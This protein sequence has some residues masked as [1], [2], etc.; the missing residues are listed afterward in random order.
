MKTEDRRTLYAQDTDRVTIDLVEIFGAFINP[1]IRLCRNAQAI[2]SHGEI[3]S[4]VGMEVQKPTKG[5]SAGSASLKISGVQRE[6]IEL[7]QSLPPGS[8]VTVRNVVVFADTP[9]DFLDGPYEYSVKGVSIES[10]SANIVLDL[11]VS[12][13]LEYYASQKK[14][15]SG[16]VP[17]IWT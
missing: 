1:T 10:A 9:D 4:P 17:A 15:I 5:G 7:V 16:E 14:Y 12:S 6:H 3:F 11:D 8:D 2:L 13:P